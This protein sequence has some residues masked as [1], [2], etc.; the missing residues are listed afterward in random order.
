MN[1]LGRFS[2]DLGH[3][4]VPAPPHKITGL[5]FIEFYISAYDFFSLYEPGC[6]TAP[7]NAG[8]TD[9]EYFHNVPE[10]YSIFFGFHFF[11]L[12]SKSFLLN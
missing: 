5:I 9:C 4:L 11:F 12:L 6:V 3:S 2:F 10:L 1:C 8:P 7:L